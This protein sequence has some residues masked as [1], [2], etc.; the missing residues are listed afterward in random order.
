L[1]ASAPK[2]V[3]LPA[4]R[5]DV[6]LLQDSPANSGA[7]RWLLHDPLRD[8]FFE[9]GLEA[10]Q[11]ISLWHRCETVPELAALASADSGRMISEDEVS[12]F[13]RYLYQMRLTTEAAGSWRELAEAAEKQRQG[14]FNQILHNY[15]FFKLPLCNPTPFPLRALSRIKAVE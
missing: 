7:P 6:R 3:P 2:P 9:I 8:S 11:L 12:E 4:L 1:I 14:W 15:L 10:F 5:E 13:A